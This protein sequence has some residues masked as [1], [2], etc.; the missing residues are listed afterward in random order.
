[1][2]AYM[3]IHIHTIYILTS[4]ICELW[5]AASLVRRA[6]QNNNDHIYT[7]HPTSNYKCGIIQN[8]KIYINYLKLFYISRILW[9]IE[10][11]LEHFQQGCRSKNILKIMLNKYLL[12]QSHHLVM[13]LNN[14]GNE[15]R[16]DNGSL[17]V[18]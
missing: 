14:L 8:T 17:V 1:M 7:D 11:L 4:E 15:S 5:S 18:L 9:G 13:L 16:A 3:Y 12:W 10:I 2:H 6:L